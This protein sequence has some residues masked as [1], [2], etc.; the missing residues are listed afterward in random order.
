MRKLLLAALLLAFLAVLAGGCG[1]DDDDAAEPT[2]AIS[3]R[4]EEDSAELV[5]PGQLT[6][7]TDNPAFPPWFEGKKRFEP[8]DPTTAPTKK[9]YEA[10]VA[11]GIARELGFADAEVKWTVVPF[12][13]A[14]RPGPKKFDFDINQISYKS[15]RAEAVDFSD[16]YYDVEQAIVAFD[17]NQIARAKSLADLKEYKLGAVVGTTS[18]DAINERIEPGREPSVYDTNNDVVAALKA[19]QIDGAA[20]DFPTALYMSAVQLDDGTVVGRLAAEEGGEYFGVVL[21]KDS[22]LTECV[23]EAIASLHDDG[24]IER[25]QQKWLGGSAPILE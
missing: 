6:I 12:N 10:E 5:T 4:C 7:G 3:D 18:L 15:E 9:G 14:F 1:G 22:P 16:S 8:W 17:S 21:E 20:V 25:L 23:N 11:Y 2:Q 24:T 13:Q 19:K